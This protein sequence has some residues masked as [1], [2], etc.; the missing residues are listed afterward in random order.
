MADARLTVWEVTQHLIRDLEE[1]GEAA[2]AALL[3]RVGGL[4]DAARELAY[5]LYSLCEKRKWS[6]EGLAYNGLVI[7][8]PEISRMAGAPASGAQEA[9]L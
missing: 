2:A 8:W 6:K 3:R 4:G 9:L 1:D 5:R 7:A